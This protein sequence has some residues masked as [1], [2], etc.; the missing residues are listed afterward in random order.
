MT[1]TKAIESPAPR[2]PGRLGKML[3]RMFM[4]RATVANCEPIGED[5]RLITLES[6]QFKGIAWTPGQKIQIALGSAF[7][8]R[9]FTPIEWDTTAGRT[10]LLAYAHGAGPGSEW[11]RSVKP[12][13]A[14][15]IFGPR[16]S[17]DVS[18]AVG[19]VVIFGDET[20]LG[21]AFAIA[22]HDPSRT[23]RCLLEL[24]SR[25]SAR[26][27]PAQLGLGETEL[28]ARQPQEAHLG[29]IEQRIRTFATSGATFVLTGKANSIQRLR[30]TLKALN[31]PT[32]RLVTKAYW[33]PGKV[34][35]D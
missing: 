10:R 34:G 21:L 12:G 32:S 16:A 28:F 26:H 33:A 9:T 19:P 7:C 8:A 25:G 27:V 1:N 35:L 22:R 4:K 15:D 11:I 30:R 3:I 23:V 20:S 18:R 13:D 5:F 14:C 2:Q 24:N 29:D 17:L 31:V 6:P